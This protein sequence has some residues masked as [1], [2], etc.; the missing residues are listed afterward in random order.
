MLGYTFTKTARCCHTMMLPHNVMKRILAMQRRVPD[1]VLHSTCNR[2]LE[3]L[4]IIDMDCVISLLSRMLSERILMTSL[5]C[6]KSPLMRVLPLVSIVWAQQI[7]KV[8]MWYSIEYKLF[9]SMQVSAWLSDIVFP[10]ELFW[11]QTLVT[12][13]AGSCQRLFPYAFA[14]CHPNFDSEVAVLFPWDLSRL[15]FVGQGLQLLA[16]RFWSFRHVYLDLLRCTGLDLENA[17]L[18]LCHIF[19]QRPVN[20]RKIQRSCE[21]CFR[22]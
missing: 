1:E 4:C 7:L 15:P 18:F 13:N 10:L 9:P 6:E 19:T 12:S 21:R 17:D 20:Y 22:R 16:I 2:L 8:L 14:R 3:L 5:T 11:M